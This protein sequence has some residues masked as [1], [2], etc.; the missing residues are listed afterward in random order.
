MLN[1]V[2]TVL[3]GPLNK[4]KLHKRSIVKNTVAIIAPV[5]LVIIAWL[6]VMLVHLHLVF[7]DLHYIT[8]LALTLIRQ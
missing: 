5:V 3:N 7:F 6:G 2:I 8:S 4:G 1:L